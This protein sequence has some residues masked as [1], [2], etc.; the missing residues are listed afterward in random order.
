MNNDKRKPSGAHRLEGV[1][2]GSD[3]LGIERREEGDLLQD[4]GLDAGNAIEEEE[5]E[6]AGGGTEGGADGT[7]GFG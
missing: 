5:G 6:D 3:L 2:L 7:P 4:V 1:V